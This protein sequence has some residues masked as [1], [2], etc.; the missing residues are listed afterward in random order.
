MDL[1]KFNV[2]KMSEMGADLELLDPASEPLTYGTGKKKKPVTIKV[3]GQDSKVWKTHN[4]DEQRKRTQKMVRK[5]GRNIDFTVSDEQRC[6]MLAKCTISWSGI[7]S[8]K[9]PLEFSYENAYNL[10]L[11]ESWVADQVD[12][13][14]TDRANFFTSA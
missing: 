13:F 11:S 10:Y 8:G 4:R 3:L 2:S 7:D 5:G 6:E 12:A 9:D 14:I 1:S